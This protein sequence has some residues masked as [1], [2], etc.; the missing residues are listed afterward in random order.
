MFLSLLRKRMGVNPN[1]IRL[2]CN[3]IATSE[4]PQW[5]RN[6][7]SIVY[8]GVQRIPLA[9]SPLQHRILIVNGNQY[10]FSSRCVHRESAQDCS[11][12][13]RV[14]GSVNFEERSELLKQ[15]GVTIWLTGLSASGK[16]WYPSYELVIAIKNLPSL[17]VHHRMRA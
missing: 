11:Q 13:I 7:E 5:H 14:L 17:T 4:F 6:R 15:K 16:V 12:T 1:M 3:Q 9:T 2:D 10:H 8:N